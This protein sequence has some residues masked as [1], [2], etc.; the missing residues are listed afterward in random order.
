M[1][2]NSGPDFKA[3]RNRIIS[4]RRF[5]KNRSTAHA[6]SYAHIAAYKISEDCAIILVI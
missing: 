5:R 4:S 2:N 6:A 1:S 3:G